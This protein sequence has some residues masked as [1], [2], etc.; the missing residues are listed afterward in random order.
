MDRICGRL[1]AAYQNIRFEPVEKSD[2]EIAKDFIQ[3][4]LERN[5]FYPLQTL[6]NY[7]ASISESF[8]AALDKADGDSAMQVVLIP[9]S[10]RKQNKLGKKHVKFEEE[11][12]K[13]AI[14]NPHDP[15]LGM[16]A[17]KEL[18]ASVES[19]GK[20]LY[21]T[22]IRLFADSSDAL[23]SMIGAMAEASAENRLI[24]QSWLGYIGLITMQKLWWTWTQLGMPSFG[25]GPNV[26]LSSFHLATLLQLPSMR[27][28]S[29]GFRRS[30][31]R[32]IPVP[33]GVPTQ[34]ENAFLQ[35]DDGTPVG[36]DEDQRY[37]NLLLLGMHGSGKTTALRHCAAPVLRDFNQSSIIVTPD[38][39]DARK[40][41]AYIPPEK[42]VYIIDLARPGEYG[43]NILADD[44]VP[45][46]Q[47]AGN[48]LAAFRTAYGESS[49][50]WQSAEFLQQP[51]YALRYVRQKY[52]DWK[53]AIPI[54]D[55]RHIRR[56]LTDHEFRDSVRNYIQKDANCYDYW[57]L[58]F[59]AMVKR[60]EYE[61]KV[62]PILNKLNELLS[63]ERVVQTLCHP[64]PITIRKIIE[65]RAVLILY[66]AKNEVG[67]ETANLF[68]NMLMSLVFQGVNSQAELPEIERVKVNLFLDE[69]H[70]YA[71]NALQ[72]LLQ[73]SRKYG[74]RTAAA[75]L[76][77]SSFSS[78]FQKVAKQLFGHKVIFRTNDQQEAEEWAKSFAL[79]Y[80][81]LFGVSDEM[82][83]KILVGP[84][85]I[86]SLP[87]FHAVARL[88][89]NGEVLPAFVAQTRPSDPRE[90]PEWIHE[91]PW[92]SGNPVLVPAIRFPEKKDG[93]DVEPTVAKASRGQKKLK[94]N[95]NLI[96]GVD[97]AKIEQL[98]LDLGLDEDRYYPV[99]VDIA[100]A[101]N[102]RK[103]A[104]KWSG[105]E[106]EYLKS[107]LLQ[108]GVC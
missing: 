67:E 78:E 80:T 85:D 104:N 47:L 30:S 4:R 37:Q 73:E 56:M 84:D 91:H 3:L 12:V 60:G 98:V 106:V 36:I 68:A 40:Y 8:F 102:E 83:D 19:R 17:Q 57:N 82:Q 88:V 42:S 32:R 99:V 5:W 49:V 58:Q 94:N 43:L 62:S 97:E 22:E 77:L 38:R 18:K 34:E 93:V 45:A 107:Q 71:N 9:M 14:K 87:R 24:P 90:N 61:K 55:F 74:A 52:R 64:T 96:E 79:R 28:R 41:L 105:D 81:N 11:R 23:Q 76:S 2:K 35:T 53:D 39:E 65:E 25:A 20:G 59:P 72:T 70:G 75:S 1:Q 26:V 54:L 92:P 46:D 7:Q 10:L 16:V 69:V 89:V 6:R 108:L 50:M 86:N 51:V 48:L 33:S 15:G 31:T 101:I 21:K 103:Q 66:T 27:L 29:A 44:D 100:E 63:S 13:R 95:Y